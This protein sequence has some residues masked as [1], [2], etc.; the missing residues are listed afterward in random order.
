[1]LQ[2]LPDKLESPTTTRA[3]VCEFRSTE[4]EVSRILGNGVPGPR[5]A[6]LAELYWSKQEA[7]WH[8][9]PVDYPD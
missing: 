5:T 6:R 7:G 1:M 2:N 3:Y 8:A 9:T 4:E